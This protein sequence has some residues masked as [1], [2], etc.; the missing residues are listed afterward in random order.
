MSKNLSVDVPAQS[1]SPQVVGL[2]QRWLNCCTS[3]HILCRQDSEPGWYP[4]GLL[5]IT[6]ETS[7][8]RLIHTSRLDISGGYGSLSHCWGGRP[9]LRLLQKNYAS[10][11]I[12][13]LFESLPKT[14]QD[15]IGICKALGLRYPSID[16]LCIVRNPSLVFTCAQD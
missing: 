1:N 10:F 2:A 6:G 4:T 12:A 9:I 15:A 14:F 8:P 3:D 5:E 11:E 7:N 16:S 13:V